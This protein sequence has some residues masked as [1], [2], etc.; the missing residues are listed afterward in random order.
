MG[1]KIEVNDTL[2]LQSGPGLPDNVE[3]GGV[4]SFRIKGRRLY[5]LRP[6]RVF[7]VREVNEKWDYVGHAL[8]LELTIDGKLDETRGVYSVLKLYEPSYRRIINAIEAPPGK[9]L[10]LP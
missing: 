10:E 1:S 4:Y 9:G 5:H 7:L 6:S 2:K 8:I 3:E